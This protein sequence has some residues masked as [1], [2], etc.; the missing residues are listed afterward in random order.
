M[1][2]DESKVINGTHGYLW[3]DGD[4]IQEVQ[5]VKATITP[6]TETVS[7]SGEMVDGTKVTGLECKGELKTNKINSRWIKLMSDSLK[8]GKQRSFT[9]ISKLAD[10]SNG[11]TER[12][13]LTGCVFTELPLIDWELKK[14]AEESLNF[15]FKNWEVLDSIE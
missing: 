2:Y 12:V 13:K 14:L 10:P 5:S 3:L 8:A 9:I 15:N 6:K 7:Q 11:G 4:L 1:A